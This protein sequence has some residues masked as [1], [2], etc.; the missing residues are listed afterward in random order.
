MLACG[1]FANED[2]ESS[3]EYDP[4]LVE[5]QVTTVCFQTQVLCGKL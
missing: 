3:S 2:I 4:L 5:S 1:E